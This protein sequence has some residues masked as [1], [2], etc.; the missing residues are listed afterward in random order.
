MLGMAILRHPLVAQDSPVD[1]PAPLL[2][3]FKREQ[4][5]ALWTFPLRFDRETNPSPVTARLAV[6][7]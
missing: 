6:S 3:I 2:P 4:Y 1:F 5:C 7:D